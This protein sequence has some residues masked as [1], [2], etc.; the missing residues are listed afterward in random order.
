M[1]HVLLSMA[2]PI[3]AVAIADIFVVVHIFGSYQVR[4][5]ILSDNIAMTEMKSAVQCSC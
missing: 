3:W 1:I 4:C 5:T 2:H